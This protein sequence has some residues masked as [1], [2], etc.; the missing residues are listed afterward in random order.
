MKVEKILVIPNVN[1]DSV[2]P[3]L[4][5]TEAFHPISFGFPGA[6]GLEEKAFPDFISEGKRGI[7]GDLVSSECIG[8][9]YQ[10]SLRFLF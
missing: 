9:I 3:P 8:P 4:P 1:L 2:G 7:D 5:A 10:S 6:D